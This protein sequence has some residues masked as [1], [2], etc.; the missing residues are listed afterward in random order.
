MIVAESQRGRRIVG[1]LDRGVDLLEAIADVC[2]KRSVRSGVLSASGT[3]ED[4]E[5]GNVDA[6]GRA[7]PLRRFASAFTIVHLQGSASEREG[8]LH[9]EA[10]AALSR[11][12]DNGVEL[13]GGRVTRARVHAVDFVIEAF[14]DLLLRRSIDGSGVS[15]LVDAIAVPVAASSARPS[16]APTTAAA[17]SASTATA[18]DPSLG[19]APIASA[20]TASASTA[21]ASTASYE[22]TAPPHAADFEARGSGHVV[23]RASEPAPAPGLSWAEVAETSAAH[24]PVEEALTPDDE[25]P[26]RMGDVLIHPSFGPCDVERIEGDVDYAHVRI[27]GKRLV[28]LSLEVFAIRRDGVD[29]RGRRRFRAVVSR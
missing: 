9:L 20:S 6:S 26:M 8:R 22:E 14:D 10:A 5:L 12:R 25:E 4:V 24:P 21:Y 27:K 3:R 18:S 15:V 1:R 19:A 16:N 29:E 28:R 23:A 11:E 13:I 2:R 7:L 17:G